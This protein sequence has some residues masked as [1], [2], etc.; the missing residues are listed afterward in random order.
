MPPLRPPEQPAGVRLPSRCATVAAETDVLVIGGGPAGIG[1]ALGAARAGASVVLAERYGFLG[2]N[3]TAA[4]VMPLMSFH[5]EARAAADAG[6]EDTLRL[7]PADHGQGEPI[8][9]GPLVEL[10]DRL[11]ETAGAI[12]PSRQTGYTVPFD[13]ESFKLVTLELLDE[14][15]VSYLFHALASGMVDDAR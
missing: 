4:L 8:V 3:A 15:G 1:A 11:V 2:G 6:T 9:A 7:L 5:N 10:L 14:S 13:P 12:A